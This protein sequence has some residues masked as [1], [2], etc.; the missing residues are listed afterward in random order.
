MSSL[1]LGILWWGLASR[2]V[3]LSLSHFLSLLMS[4]GVGGVAGLEVEAA[5]VVGAAIA[6]GTVVV[7]GASIVVGTVV[8]VGTA[9]VVVP[10]R[11]YPFILL[12]FGF[13]V[14]KNKVLINK[15]L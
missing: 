1:Y 3:R 14:S 5:R 11:F 13:S 2:S 8:V 9:G 6:V 7:V 12:F 10:H 4:W 15:L